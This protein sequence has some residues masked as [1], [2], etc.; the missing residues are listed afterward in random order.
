MAACQECWSDEERSSL[1]SARQEACLLA[2][3]EKWSG[4]TPQLM[5]FHSQTLISCSLG[6]GLKKFVVSLQLT[7]SSLI[8]CWLQPIQVVTSFTKW[9]NNRN[10]SKPLRQLKSLLL[11][12][13]G[14]LS[15]FQ[16]VIISPK[17][18]RPR[19]VAL[20]KSSRLSIETDFGNTYCS[21][22]F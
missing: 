19:H 9:Q 2:M 16:T 21:V 20:L 7:V 1:F 5:Y 11:L 8:P 18:G 12:N 22:S 3:T 17:H 4:D 10:S 6:R 14:V 13:P 15:V